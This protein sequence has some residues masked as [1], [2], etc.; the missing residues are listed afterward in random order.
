MDKLT[1]GSYITQKRKEQKIPL[2]DMAKEL[3]ISKFYLCNIEKDRRTMTAGDTLEKI[4]S[5]L[6]LNTNDTALLFDLAAK[7]NNVL[8]AADLTEYINEHDIVRTALRTA[9]DVG[10]T[11]EVWQAFIEQL[12]ILERKESL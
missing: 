5:V 9:R 6:H 10:A 4:A 1:L 2:L 7:S 11:D 3:G 8:I 12:R